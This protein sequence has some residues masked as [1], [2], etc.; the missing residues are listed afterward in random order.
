MHGAT[1]IIVYN[2]FT[3]RCGPQHFIFRK[4]R[5]QNYS[6]MS[7]SPLSSVD[8]RN[9]CAVLPFLHTV[10]QTDASLMTGKIYRVYSSL[11]VSYVT[12]IDCSH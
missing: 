5:E 6:G 2:M 12:V 3:P 4:Y 10:L 8:F 11:V 1:H 9:M 7:L